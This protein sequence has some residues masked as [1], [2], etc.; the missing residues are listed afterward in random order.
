M[1]NKKPVLYKLTD[2]NIGSGLIK[3]NN[4]F[5]SPDGSFYLAKGYTGCNPSHQLESSA[6][7][8]LRQ[9]IGYNIK[10]EECVGYFN[11]LGVNYKNVVDGKV[12]RLYYLRSILVHY[13]GYALFARQEIIESYDKRNRFFDCSLVPNPEF[14]DKQITTM[15]IEVLKRLFELND[16]GTVCFNPMGQSNVEVLEKVLQHDEHHSSWHR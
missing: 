11:N 12:K 6:L 1:E 7:A 3:H 14:Y 15:Q 9:T 13:Y 8:I 10:N 4:A 5:I 16:D 2:I